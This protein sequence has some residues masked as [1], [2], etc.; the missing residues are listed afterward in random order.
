MLLA[1]I[2]VDNYQTKHESISR[3]NGTA[4]GQLEIIMEAK[5]KTP[6]KKEGMDRSHAPSLVQKSAFYFLH[7]L[8][9]L[10]C[11]YLLL[12]GLEQ[13]GS[14]FGKLWAVND[15]TRAWLVFGAAV[16]YF[17][18]HGVT[19]FYLLMRNISWSEALGLSLFMAFFEIGL[20]IL[21][22]GLLR[23]TALP[24]GWLDGLGVALVLFGS[25]LNTGSE[26]QR[27]W[28]KQDPVNKGKCYTEELFS[29]SMHINFFG[30]T[31]LFTGWALLTGVGW[32]LL[33]PAMITVMFVYLHI[34]SLDLYLE[35]RYGES[36][37]EYARRTKKFIPFVY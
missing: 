11:G 19:L 2:K 26:V 34:P 35:G 10:V 27:K 24:L 3:V 15:P 23:S 37:K 8:S 33:L 1:W 17:L 20:C 12:G 18:R 28:W 36:F 30:D 4:I 22:T 29:Y 25:Y 7:F 14:W 16:L 5:E 13:L 6:E 21:A 31:L 32:A 9:L